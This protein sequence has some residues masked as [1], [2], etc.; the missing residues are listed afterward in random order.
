MYYYYFLVK[1]GSK[2]K[3]S[4]KQVDV[5]ENIT[6]DCDSDGSN[7]W[8]FKKDGIFDKSVFVAS[9]KSIDLQVQSLHDGIFYCYGTDT[10]RKHRF[11]DEVVVFVYG[12]FILIICT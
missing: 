12:K 1:D 7:Y 5:G 8:F 11:L 10:N 9:S 3:D 2:I 6:L 4:Y